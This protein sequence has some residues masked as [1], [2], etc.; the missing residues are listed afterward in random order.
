[1]RTSFFC[2]TVALGLL[3]GGAQIANA[4]LVK[5]GSF[6]NPASSGTSELAPTSTYLTDW[7]VFNDSL[8][9]ISTGNGFT[10]SHLD[11]SL[12]LT[13]HS[14]RGVGNYGG[15]KQVISTVVG[16]TYSISFDVGAWNGGTSKVEV[17]AGDLTAIGSATTD[18]LVWTSFSSVFTAQDTTTTI[19]LLG[20]QASYEGHFIGLDNVNVTLRS[21]PNDVPE[22]ASLPLFGAGLLALVGLHRRRQGGLKA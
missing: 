6:E 7:T 16:A 4:N 14:A 20:L 8:A 3:L 19:K 10:A 15:V 11:Y 17:T 21:T 5:N 9:H 18:D 2:R 22:P 1:M 13:G 12:D